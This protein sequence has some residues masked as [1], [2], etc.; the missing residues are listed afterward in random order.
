[1]EQNTSGPFQETLGDALANP[2]LDRPPS[3]GWALEQA[4]AEAQYPGDHR[5]YHHDRSAPRA[6]PAA[7]RPAE[8]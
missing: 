3:L 1:M 8:A 5:R 4:D 6:A 2:P 7:D